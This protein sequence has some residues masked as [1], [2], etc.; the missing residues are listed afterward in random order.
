MWAGASI[1]IKWFKEKAEKWFEHANKEYCRRDNCKQESRLGIE[2]LLA[3][4]LFSRKG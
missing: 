4:Y 2:G 1:W 3:L